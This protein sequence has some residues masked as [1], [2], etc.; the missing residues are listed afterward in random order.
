M[1][2]VVTGASGFIGRNVLLRAPREWQITA[3]AHQTPGLEAF[4]REHRLDHVRVNRCDLRDSDAVRAAARTS[5]APADAALYLAANGDPARSSRDPGDRN[6]NE[7][8]D[9]VDSSLVFWPTAD[10]ARPPG[11][12]IDGNA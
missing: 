6:R 12:A 4:V 5:G 11:G 2:V 3:I 1:H 10:M 9:R 8:I 7:L